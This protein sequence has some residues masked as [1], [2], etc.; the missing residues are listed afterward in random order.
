[1]SDGDPSLEV[2][3]AAILSGATGEVFSLPPPARHH[4]VIALMG[5]RFRQSD[6]QGFV[7]RCGKFVMRK[8]ALVCA[9]RAGQLK[10]GEAKWPAHGLFSEDLW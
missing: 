8:A 4:D 6:E 1:M 2:V 10:D 5:D 3:A 7:L 9:L